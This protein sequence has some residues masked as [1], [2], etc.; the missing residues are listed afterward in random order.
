VRSMSAAKIFA[1]VVLLI[2]C[3]VT[4]K[5]GAAGPVLGVVE[6]TIFRDSDSLTLYVP[7]QGEVSLAGF[8]FVADNRTYGLEDFISFRGLPFDRLPTP[9]CF[10]LIRNGSNPPRPLDCPTTLILT[11]N[12]SNADVF[13]YNSILAVDITFLIQ[14]S[15]S[16]QAFCASGAVIC[17]FSFIPSVE[18]ST[19]TPEPSVS[20]TVNA[21]ATQIIAAATL[22]R[23]AQPTPLII[24]T[25]QATRVALA[26]D[27]HVEVQD[28]GWNNIRSRIFLRVQANPAIEWLQIAI[29]DPRSGNTRLG[30]EMPIVPIIG[31]TA[32]LDVSTLPLLPGF[33][34]TLR[35]IPFDNIRS[36]PL[37]EY[38]YAEVTFNAGSTDIG[39]RITIDNP[40]DSGEARIRVTRLMSDIAQVRLSVRQEPF[41]GNP[42]WSE[43]INVTSSE[44]VTDPIPSLLP[45]RRY[46]VYYTGFD[47]QRNLIINETLG[48]SFIFDATPLADLLASIGNPIL[49]IAL[50]ILTIILFRLL[51][52]YQSDWREVS[53]N[54]APWA[55]TSWQRHAAIQKEETRLLAMDMA[56]FWQATQ[57]RGISTF[58]E[59]HRRLT[60]SLD[61]SPNRNLIPIYAAILR[62]V[63][64]N[65]DRVAL[66]QT[67]HGEIGVH[68]AEMLYR[69][70]QA[71]IYKM[72]INLAPAYW[73]IED[74]LYTFSIALPDI[75]DSGEAIPESI[76]K[77]ILELSASITSLNDKLNHST[78]M[79]WQ[80]GQLLDV[81]T[82]SDRKTLQ[83]IEETNNWA[84]TQ[85]RVN[86]VMDVDGFLHELEARRALISGA[87]QRPVE[88]SVINRENN[89]V[90][91]RRVEMRVVLES[92]TA[93]LDFAS[94]LLKRYIEYTEASITQILQNIKTV[95]DMARVDESLN[96]IAGGGFGQLVEDA[97]RNLLDIRREVSAALAQPPESYGRRLAMLDAYLLIQQFQGQLKG[98]TQ[99]R[100]KEW[101]PLVAT[102]AELFKERRQD[103]ES[104][105]MAYINPYVT[106][107]PIKANRLMLFKGRQHIAQEIVTRLRGSGN[108]TLLLYGPRRMGKSSFLLHLPNLLPARY[109][110][111]YFD[112]QGAGATQSEAN[113]CYLL[114]RAI[115]DV[116]RKGV[117]SRRSMTPL[118]AAPSLADFKENAL[119]RLEDW[120]NDSVAPVLENRTLLITIDEFEK[121]GE[122]IR[123]GKMTTA[124][125][126]QIRHM[127]QHREELV[128]MFTGVQSLDALVPDAA[129]YFISVVSIELGYLDHDAAEDLIRNPASEQEGRVPRYHD[130][131]VAEILR[132][133][134]CQPFLVQA[135]CS[136]TVTIANN[137]QISLIQVEHVQRAAQIAQTRQINFFRNIWD[138]AGEEGQVFL[139][140]LVKNHTQNDTSVSVIDDLLHRHVI[141]RVNG[142]FE[143]EVP[144]VRE[145]IVKQG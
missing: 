105:G 68:Y 136:E 54:A 131:A 127:I 142:S 135:I 101:S 74:L 104:Q 90:I 73:H 57:D 114:A 16:T 128:F 48:T 47:A 49:W 137:E 129:S 118:Q 132:L 7:D 45:N 115:Y 56:T 124:L 99:P 15:E 14:N 113:F 21:T 2:L 1:L 112:A 76:L 44:I 89:G 108:P 72:T 28:I 88:L 12:L 100:A 61:R 43:T 67:E 116:M 110:P 42:I 95:E 125:L 37:L 31:G 103:E 19:L 64:L 24:A 141:R 33:N 6:A 87:I 17:Q 27:R 59:L 121:I 40:R 25:V 106:G 109:I 85:A 122:A 66:I 82:A 11:Q 80:A 36:V 30:D 20:P 69:V 58:Q 9:I 79:L 93:A 96:T 81:F 53:G 4:S 18:V 134:H 107:N 65:D 55:I 51:R 111:V 46:S 32:E 22:T 84:I 92:I 139:R 120:L 91:I 60:P 117:E 75:P 23:L 35:L 102:I 133:T 98:S 3:F 38:R 145:W 8:A 144:L 62:D 123:E 143:V 39:V 138:E 29:L 83:L 119:T 50:V 71:Q 34:Y 41:L 70:T 63:V 77:V 10:R 5:I 13:W 78:R 94:G 97:I 86:I 126:D 26:D 130:A 52:L 140:N